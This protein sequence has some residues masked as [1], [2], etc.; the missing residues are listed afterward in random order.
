MRKFFDKLAGA[1][2]RA[3]N[4]LVGTRPVQYAIRTYNRAVIKTAN[5]VLWT[6]YGGPRRRRVFAAKPLNF[7]VR[8]A[9]E[10]LLI[11]T[12]VGMMAYDLVK[13]VVVTTV[14]WS[15]TAVAYAWAA[16]TVLWTLEVGVYYYLLNTAWNWFIRGLQWA[17]H[18]VAGTPAMPRRVT[19]YIPMREALAF[20]L[21]ALVMLHAGLARLLRRV[22]GDK[23][24]WFVVQKVTDTVARLHG[25]TYDFWFGK[26]LPFETPQD[27]GDSYAL[28]ISDFSEDGEPISEQEKVENWFISNGYVL[29]AT[30]APDK[31]DA[32][33][34]NEYMR[35]RWA[36]LNAAEIATD[37]FGRTWV[38]PFK[39]RPLFLDVATTSEDRR[40]YADQ[41]IDWMTA[42]DK[43]A[44]SFSY[45]RHW[46][47]ALADQDQNFCKD[48]ALQRRERAFCH[49]KMKGHQELLVEHI[50]K[51]FDSW[52]SE[53]QVSEQETEVSV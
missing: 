24:T 3:W 7:I 10:A 45:G 51:G 8:V 28:Y 15:L 6:F 31:T 42:T 36:N 17:Y 4:W 34:F 2:S 48:T 18:V 12:T 27:G 11:P 21:G 16:L 23:P 49:S 20:E 44:K 41:E 43:V 5:P 22:I 9:W 25:P 39:N 1:V 47:A 14:K 29:V 52:I 35:E 13:P 38:V 33:V 37:E 30:G 50:L 53:Y 32:E 46:A 40:F 26:Q 19:R